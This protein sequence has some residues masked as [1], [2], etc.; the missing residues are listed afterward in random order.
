MVLM[1]LKVSILYLRRI[2]MGPGRIWEK[3]GIPIPKSYKEKKVCTK[4]I[5]LTSM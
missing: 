3:R 4:Q 1:G 2:W 5:T